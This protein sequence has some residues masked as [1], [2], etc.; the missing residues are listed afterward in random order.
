MRKIVDSNFLQDANLGRY[1][2]KSTVNLVVLT[3]YAAMEAYKGDTLASI[4]KSM[5][6]VAR[7]PK[8][9][10]ILKS[11]K[12]ACGLSARGP[13]LQR[14]LIDERQ[15]REFE[16]FCKNLAAAERGDRAVQKLI[17]QAGREADEQMARILADAPKTIAAIEGIAA[18]YTNE[19]LRL[20]RTG[21]TYT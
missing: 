16:I 11:T 19:E 15:T 8:Q 13:G 6:L 4:Y 17:L 12:A 20:L 18:R 10:V 14:R 1:L 2:S 9:V 3:D 5:A 21:R 7:F